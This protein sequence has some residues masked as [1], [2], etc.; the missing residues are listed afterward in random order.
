MTD[1]IEIKLKLDKKEYPILFNLKKKEFDKT[2][3]KIFKTGYQIHFPSQDVLGQHQEYNELKERI[4]NIKEELSDEINNSELGNKIQ[5]SCNL[6]ESSL[7]KLIGISSN[8]YKKGNIAENILEE[9]FS[10]RYGDI[11]FERKG[12]VAHS[13]DAWLYLPNK[14]IIMLESKNYTTTVNKDEINKLQNDMI[15][16]HIK[17]AV[18]ISFNSNIQGMKEMDFHTFTHSNETYYCVMIS[19]LSDD[20]HKLD[21]GLQIIRKLINTIE[22]KEAFPWVVQDISQSLFELNKLI[23]KNYLLRDSFYSM[24]REIQKN[25][26]SHYTVLRDY[27]YDLDSKIKE[28]THKIN[29]TMKEPINTIN[30]DYSQI[31]DQNKDKKVIGI[32]VRLVDII[33]TKKWTLEA[34]ENDWIVKKNQDNDIIFATIKIQAKKVVFIHTETDININLHLGKDVENNKNYDLIILL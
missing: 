32:I 6:L 10:Q 30:Y 5:Q 31:I 22:N 1:S 34:S 17:W 21:L 13:G 15:T 3:F 4:Q 16:H 33:Q 18:F 11:E 20:I 28:I 14:Q 19:N 25:L 23:E 27:Q 24:E 26:S 2:I 12:Q 9:I 7:S 29:N 8:S